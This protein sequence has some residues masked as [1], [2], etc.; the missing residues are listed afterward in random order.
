[1]PHLYLP[2][3]Q[4]FVWKAVRPCCESALA[5]TV[6]I[7][8][9]CH[10]DWLPQGS[11]SEQGLESVSSKEQLKNCGWQLLFKRQRYDLNYSKVHNQIETEVKQKKN[12]PFQNQQSHFHSLLLSFLYVYFMFLLLF[13]YFIA[14]SLLPLSIF[15]FS[16]C[17]SSCFLFI[18][19]LSSLSLYS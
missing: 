8:K 2:G 17:V 1:M 19:L 16:S 4:T 3:S 10:L 5:P 11:H 12:E 9:L 13:Y 14:P 6:Q 15:Y 7:Q 18:F